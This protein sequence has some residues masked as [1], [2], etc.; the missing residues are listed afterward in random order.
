MKT[1]EK[2]ARVLREAGL[3]RLA[4]NAMNGIY[5]EFETPLALP[6]TTLVGELRAAG[7]EDLAQRVIDGEWDCTREEAD[8]WAKKNLPGLLKKLGPHA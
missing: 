2:L 8:A 5:D 7:R 4:V 6:L 3:K 1:K